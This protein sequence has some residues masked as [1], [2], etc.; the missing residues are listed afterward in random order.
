ME[1]IKKKDNEKNVDVV[2]VI[3]GEKHFKMAMTKYNELEVSFSYDETKKGYWFQ[4]SFNVNRED[5]EVY[6][7]VDGIFAS[8]SGDVYF[9]T[10]GAN[11]VLLNED[12][13]YR[14][15][16]MEESHFASDEIKCRFY[17]DSLENNS[18]KNLYKRLNG[19]NLEK[20]ELVVNKPKTLSKTLQKIVE[21]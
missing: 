19:L 2:E 10:L 11:L 12:G 8:Y 13:N 7:A 20:N 3:N 4:E 5:D 21:K 9:D 18:M 1:I 6:K 15:L 17:D 16:F 14:F